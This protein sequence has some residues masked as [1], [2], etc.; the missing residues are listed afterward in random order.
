MHGSTFYFLFS[1]FDVTQSFSPSPYV[2]I[3]L[4]LAINACKQHLSHVVLT[5]NTTESIFKHHK[6]SFIK[7]H[8][9]WFPSVQHCNWFGFR[10]SL[11]LS[12]EGAIFRDE[13]E[14]YFSCSRLARRDRDYHMTILVFRDENEI[15]FCYSHVSRRDR[16]F[17]KSFLVVE[18]EKMQLTL[19]ENS[20]DRE[21]SL[22]SALNALLWENL[23]KAIDLCFWSS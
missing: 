14:N 16:D 12:R 19:V 7:N 8:I 10:I 21:F 9:I 11:S 1:H 13:I 15:P 4:T 22:T 2:V 6:K 23:F 18:R 20:R 17:R 3:F 5:T